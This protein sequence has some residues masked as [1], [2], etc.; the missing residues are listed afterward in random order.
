MLRLD[1][2][3]I[4]TFSCVHLSAN[5]D[6]QKQGGGGSYETV[7]II[8]HGRSK[9]STTSY[10]MVTSTQAPM[11][12]D[13]F[14][15]RKS[16]VLQSEQQVRRR[17]LKYVNWSAYFF[18]GAISIFFLLLDFLSLSVC[19]HTFFFFFY[20]YILMNAASQEGSSQLGCC[21]NWT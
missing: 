2:Q 21:W 18:R 16:I 15:S 20:Q 5:S 6:W 14:I 9:S 8:L 11:A 19:F 4:S 12:E 7:S 10:N 3:L 17:K 13:S 1:M